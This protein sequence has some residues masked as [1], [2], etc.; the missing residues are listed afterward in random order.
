M[1]SLSMLFFFYKQKTAY[2]RRIS[3]WSSDVCSSDLWWEG[4]TDDAPPH[5][6]DWEGNPWTPASGRPAAHPNSRFTV[7]AAQC[8][9]IAAD[10]DAPEG[11]PL[12][13]ILFGGRRATNVPPVVEATDWTHGVFLGSTISSEKTAAADGTVGELRRA[14]FAMLPFRGHHLARKNVG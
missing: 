13:V 2:E 3:D 5:L 1:Y 11:V 14:P 8:P 4:L 9:Q 7:A 12:D 10:W 6:T